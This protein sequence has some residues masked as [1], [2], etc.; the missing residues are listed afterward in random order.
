M[1]MA[2]T[3]PLEFTN[4]WVRRELEK[5]EEARKAACQELRAETGT[6]RVGHHRGLAERTKL[7][8]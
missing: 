4:T 5:K 3:D 7:G 6:G 2:K 1:A 8:A